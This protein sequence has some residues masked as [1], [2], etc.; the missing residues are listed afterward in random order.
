MAKLN[1]RYIGGHGGYPNPDSGAVGN[2][3]QEYQVAREIANMCRDITIAQGH[4]AVVYGEQMAYRD[5][6]NG[7][8][9]YKLSNSFD[10]NLEIHL[11][12][13]GQGANGTEI[14]VPTAEE[15]TGLEQKIMN[16]LT[17]FFKIRDGGVKKKDFMV[18]RNIKANGGWAALL[19]VF[20]ID[21]ANDVAIWKANKQAICE[22]IVK[23]VIEGHGETWK[24]TKT[25]G[26]T[27][28]DTSTNNDP[29]AWLGKILG[30]YGDAMN[31]WY[32]GYNNDDDH[33]AMSVS[34]AYTNSNSPMKFKH[35]WVDNIRN[36]FV[37][38]GKWHKRGDGYK[39]KRNDVII[40]DYE[41]N[42]VGNHVGLVRYSDNIKVYTREGNTG[43]DGM[44]RDKEYS[45]SDWTIMGYGEYTPPV[46]TKPVETKPVETPKE[47]TKETPASM[48]E[49]DTDVK[50]Y[51]SV[52]ALKADKS[53]VTL[54]KGKYYVYKTFKDYLNISANEKMPGAWVKIEPKLYRVY[55]QVGAYAVED[56][57][58]AKL[59]EIEKLGKS[60]IIQ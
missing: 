36:E 34:W 3:L 17:K 42:D 20:F 31:K 12:A 51:I 28:S 43:W 38:K 1:I 45:L 59:A 2:G 35:A 30:Q 21:N 58:K 46:A 10:Y 16:N 9:D 52:E 7:V 24:P 33:C 25:T 29:V 44:N 5:M 56:N 50:G 47:E 13:F 11:N 53:P 60:G 40:F 18:I 55:E 39:P 19:E 15:T 54:P 27:T 8:Y 14:F 37:K 48:V 26:G 41:P 57:A 4:N 32:Y 6:N 49:V 23:G 22:A